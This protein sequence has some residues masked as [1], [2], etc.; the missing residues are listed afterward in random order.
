MYSSAAFDFKDFE[1]PI[2]FFFEEPLIIGTLQKSST[3]FADI[4]YQKAKTEQYDQYF[5]Y[6]KQDSTTFARATHVSRNQMPSQ[7][8]KIRAQVRLKLDQKMV[9]YGRV[10][11]TIFSGLEQIG[12][13]MESLMHIGFLLV[14]FFQE[15]LFKSSFIRQLYQISAENDEGNIQ[16]EEELLQIINQK[17]EMGE[18]IIQQILEFL[19]VKRAR[20]IYGYRHIFQY[21]TKC[22]CLRDKAKMRKDYSVKSHYLYEK[23]NEKLK[24]E[25][26]VVNLMKTLRQ[27]KNMAQALMPEKNRL[28][29]KF[30]RKNVIEA[31]SSS[32]NSDQYDYDPMKLL[33]S[34][35]NL[36][37]LRQI[38]K[39]SKILDNGKDQKMDKIDKSLIKGLFR[40]R[41]TN[42]QKEIDQTKQTHMTYVTQQ[43]NGNMGGV[44]G[45]ISKNRFVSQLRQEQTSEFTNRS[46]IQ[47]RP[48]WSNSPTNKM[49]QARSS[50]IQ[51]I[52][53]D[54]LKNSMNNQI[55]NGD[56]SA[57]DFNG[58]MD[59]MNHSVE[60]ANTP[61]KI[62]NSPIGGY[63]Q[64]HQLI[65]K[66]STKKDKINKQETKKGRQ[67]NI[68]SLE[69]AFSS[70]G[71][72]GSKAANG[73][74]EKMLKKDGKQQMPYLMQ[75]TFAPKRQVENS[76]QKQAEVTT[77]D[78]KTTTKKKTI[79]KAI[80]SLP[81]NQSTLINQN[82]FGARDKEIVEETSSLEI[83]EMPFDF[84]DE[85]HR[86]DQRF[87]F[88]RKANI[89]GR[90]D[91]L[92]SARFEVKSTMNF[93]KNKSTSP[94]ESDISTPHLSEFQKIS[95]QNRGDL[96]KKTT[97]SQFKVHPESKVQEK[98]KKAQTIQ[99]K[100]DDYV[101]QKQTNF[102]E[103]ISPI[104]KTPKNQSHTD[105]QVKT[106]SRGRTEAAPKRDAQQRTQ[107]TLQMKF[108]DLD[109][110]SLSL[111]DSSLD[112]LD[113][114]KLQTGPLHAQR[115]QLPPVK[116]IEAKVQDSETTDEEMGRMNHMFSQGGGVAKRP[117]QHSG[118][119]GKLG[120][121]EARGGKTQNKQY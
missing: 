102:D 32:S 35:H 83:E 103:E 60:Q 3:E 121:I 111:A 100:R 68:F 4:F 7:G 77:I 21:L 10:A 101:G 97:E 12:G 92:D 23:G 59:S 105:A 90:V 27:L 107:H 26:D 73:I 112:G 66:A 95:T 48:L 85:S 110:S 61:P 24:R 25:L 17:E 41:S 11:D 56:N 99:N 69:Q 40:R 108:V 115:S 63:M 39:I 20:F 58:L 80:A 57:S 22:L 13:F 78:I 49:K 84:S 52:F 34:K 116:R 109:Q 5:E 89:Q 2:K 6:W 87:T 36:L 104:Q 43:S 71:Q 65:R 86:R 9:I 98:H 18:S 106:V 44:S 88:H 118:G 15:R 93:K 31:T 54:Q 82:N 45:F 16:N 75:N 67:Q 81:L 47:K 117:S 74:E 46:S 28:L 42:K 55:A 72:E 19:I 76:A 1:T 119:I 14:F 33:K 64:R 38:A 51:Y 70:S 29:L 79:T 113:Y 8:S 53:S 120:T 30:Q 37:K 114:L 94:V 96:Q 91:N 62:A 50:P